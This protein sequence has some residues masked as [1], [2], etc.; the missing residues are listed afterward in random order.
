[1]HT[2]AQADFACYGEVGQCQPKYCDLFDFNGYPRIQAWMAHM[3]QLQGT[4][5]IDVSTIAQTRG[6]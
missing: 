2:R 5:N 6:A 3:E 4:T 1:M